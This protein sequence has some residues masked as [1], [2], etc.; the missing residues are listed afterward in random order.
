MNCD[1]LSQHL[2]FLTVVIFSR[3]NVILNQSNKRKRRMKPNHKAAITVFVACGAFMFCTLPSTL[4][5]NTQCP[6]YN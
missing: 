2:R 3:V 6:T 5:G 4:I 1:I